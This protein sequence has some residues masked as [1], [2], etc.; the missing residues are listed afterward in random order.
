VVRPRTPFCLVEPEDDPEQRYRHMR[1]R[2]SAIT[3]GLMCVV[4]MAD[5]KAEDAEGSEEVGELEGAFAEEALT[6]RQSE[7]SV[8]RQPSGSFASPQQCLGAF[9]WPRS[10]E[11]AG[12]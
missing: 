8:L 5:D 2:K 12:T 6:R 4:H 7:N 3:S 11:G 10:P 1:P 9:D